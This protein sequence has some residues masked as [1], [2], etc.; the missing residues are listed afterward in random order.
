MD[1]PRAALRQAERLF[2]EREHALGEE[3]EAARAARDAAIR[4]AHEAGMST[5][6]IAREIGLSFQRV[7]QILREQ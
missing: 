4:A 6:E 5:R 2:R 7:S 3:L 1:D